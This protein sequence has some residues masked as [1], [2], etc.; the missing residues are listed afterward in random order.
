MIP[1]NRT[2][3]G[4]TLIEVLAVLLIV[5]ILSVILISNLW[6]AKEAAD[7]S[8]TKTILANVE[9][10]C[11]A[12][13]RETGDYPPSH[14]A[15]DLTSN[16]GTNVGIEACVAALWSNGF[17]A[18]GAFQD[19]QL[20][21]VDGDSATESVSDLGR[22]LLEL[23]DAWGNPIAY[24]HHRDYKDETRE[25]MTLHPETGEE[26][27]SRV[28]ARK[29]ATTGRYQRHTKYQLISAGSD[30]LFGTE[31]DITNFED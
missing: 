20:D 1:L 28:L 18:N 27:L 5:G 16:Q 10:A 25:Y 11:D 4:F 3:A 24:I 15:N 17:E 8:L 9:S 26:T 29:N 23:V 12:Y 31:D 13:E 19:D 21:N 30:G 22:S 2:R 6:G 7:V 14:F